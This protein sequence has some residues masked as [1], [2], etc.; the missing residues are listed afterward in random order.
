MIRS[1]SRIHQCFPELVAVEELAFVDVQILDLLEVQ[2]VLLQQQCYGSAASFFARR[3]AAARSSRQNG[4]ELR[5][6]AVLLECFW[7]V[8]CGLGL[9]AE[10]EAA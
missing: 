2:P 9:Y 6:L 1:Y 4:D 10:T 7:L 8:C 3:S 5:A